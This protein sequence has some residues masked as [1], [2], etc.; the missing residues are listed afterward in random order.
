[1]I[2]HERISADPGRQNGAHREC[3]LSN[4]LLICINYMYNIHGTRRKKYNII[5]LQSFY[6]NQK[7][8]YSLNYFHLPKMW[9]HNI[10]VSSHN[11]YPSTPPSLRASP[12]WQRPQRRVRDDRHHPARGKTPKQRRKEGY[13]TAKDI[14]SGNLTLLWKDPPFFMGKST[15]SMAIFNSYVKLPEGRIP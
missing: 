15:I 11:V 8:H 10:P 5:Y 12:A 4:Y 2:F 1:M 14:P 3:I 6:M 7:N 13:K 9:T